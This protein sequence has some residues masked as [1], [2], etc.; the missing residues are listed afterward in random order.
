MNELNDNEL[1][2]V[3]S[4]SVDQSVDRAFQKYMPGQPGQRRGHGRIIKAVILVV[5]AAVIIF[6]G[7]RF[8]QN[9]KG[10][11][12]RVDPVED[13]DLTLE[14]KGIFGFTA[15][16]FA[17]PILGKAEEK[18]LLIVEEKDASV[19]TTITDAG[20]MNLDVFTKTQVLTIHGTGEYTIDLSKITD[21]DI[22]LSDDLVITVQI[23]HAELHNVSYDP[24]KTEIG[25]LDRGWLAIG[26]VQMDP[27]QMKNVESSAVDE[28]TKALDTEENMEEADRFAKLTATEE[29]QKVVNTVS[30]SYKLEVVFQ[31]EQEE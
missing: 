13:H 14:S 23:P 9:I 28:L 4:D 20:L 31:E 1:K 5:I 30:P 17:E 19:N 12:G 21:D 15:A 26:K 6:A 29:L 27:E 7:Y 18:K 10:L 8:R 11:T 2:K 22:S 16:D 3:I 25:D 24:D